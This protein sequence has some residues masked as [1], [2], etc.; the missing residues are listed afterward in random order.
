MK[1]ECGAIGI[2][3]MLHSS[4]LILLVGLSD[5]GDFSPRKVTIWSTTTNSV[6]CS[7]WPL[8]NKIQ[9]AK[10]NK[11]RMM[12]QESKFLHIYSTTEMKIIHT[13]EIGNVQIGRLILSPSYHKNNFVCYSSS[14]D[15]GVVKI[16]DLNYLT[17]KTNINAHKSTISKLSINSRGDLLA[18]CSNKG[19]II[20]IFSLPKGDKLF[21][22]KRGMTNAMIYSL[23]FSS[24]S[25]KVIMTSDTGTL[26]VFEL[27][28]EE[29]E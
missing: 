27:K 2:V 24:D 12:L 17:Y 18:T 6:V 19:T 5:L 14:S 16:Y 13:L 22:Y 25:E 26:H 7:S 1:I 29:F 10:V 8:N 3:E 15:D 4:S 21:T 20:R 11:Q 28:E 23:N 9:I